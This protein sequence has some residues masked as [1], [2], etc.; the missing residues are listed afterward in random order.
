MRWNS[1]LLE[2]LQGGSNMTGTNCDLFTHSQSR[3]YLNHLVLG[4]RSQG[5]LCLI[6]FDLLRL[7]ISCYFDCR[8]EETGTF[9]ACSVSAVGLFECKLIQEELPGERITLER[10]SAWCEFCSAQSLFHYPWRGVY[11]Y[12]GNLDDVDRS[13]D[14]SSE[15]AFIF[16]RYCNKNV[17]EG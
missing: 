9:I 4:L 6:Q 12:V 8:D 13:V 11:F 5:R 7:F 15:E 17:S 2:Q 3:S 14:A 10:G 16:L 1:S